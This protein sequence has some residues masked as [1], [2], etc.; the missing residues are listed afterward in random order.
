MSTSLRE[1]IDRLEKEKLLLRIN[2]VLS[3][4]YEIPL[5]IREF[6]N[7]FALLFE[8]IEGYSNFRIVAG[9][10]G[11]RY[12]LS[13]ALGLRENELLQKINEAI[14]NPEPLKVIAHS[15]DH[16]IKEG[17]DINI[18][19]I[20]T[21]YEKD[22]GPYITAGIVIAKD[23]ETSVRNASYHRMTPIGRDLLVVRVVKRDL[24]HYLQK[25]QEMGKDL[26]AA[27][28]I[29]VDPATAIAG[30]ASVPIDVDELEVASALLEKPLEITKGVTVN[31]EYPASAEI[32]LEGRFLVD[33]MEEEGPFVDITGTYDIIRKQPVFQISAILLRRNPIFHTI[34]PAGIEHKTLMGIPREARIYDSVRGVTIVRDVHL[35]TWGCGWL[36]CIISIEKRHED[37]PIDAGLAAFA[38]H[39]SLKK[40]IIVD[41]DINIRSCE[42][43]YWA[44][45]TRAHP[46]RDYIIIPR[47]KGS[48]LDHSGTPRAR[49]IVDATI[50]GE[51]TLFKRANIPGSIKAEKIISR[52]RNSLK[53]C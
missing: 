13:T 21:F 5:V 31:I 7:K 47:G 37:E 33:S 14:R 30:A 34:L 53:L 52:I 44:V 50:K 43:V 42:D 27:V 18:L 32:V 16:T 4:R 6:E 40:V 10:Y 19:P 51:K 41:P 23:P 3:P 26:E 2:H 17:I 24:W 12:R 46:I 28:V 49:L 45:I 36:E 9:I 39:P 35:A 20:P 29:G 11:D 15:F 1:T 38:A 48:S 22:K 25:A 8:N